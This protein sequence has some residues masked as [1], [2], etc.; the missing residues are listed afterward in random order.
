MGIKYSEEHMDGMPMP[1]TRF[2]GKNVKDLPDFTLA[3]E[4]GENGFF[5]HGLEKLPQGDLR[6]YFER[7][8]NK[9]FFGSIW[10][11]DSYL[12]AMKGVIEQDS[13]IQLVEFDLEEPNHMLIRFSIDVELPEL[14]AVFELADK[15]EKEILSKTHHML[16]KEAQ[17]MN[18]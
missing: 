15:M 7:N 1:R 4:P 2:I 11:L 8:G 6:L 9:K 17:E 14:D 5:E 13:S 18:V 10:S 3:V 16:I 12:S